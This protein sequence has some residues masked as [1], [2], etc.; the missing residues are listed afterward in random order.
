[1]F[2]G[3]GGVFAYRLR[4]SRV[5]LLLNRFGDVDRSVHELALV[6]PGSVISTVVPT[7]SW[8]WTVIW[9]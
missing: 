7:P 1:M 3:F 8:L 2:G 9:P 5:L 6:K 4:Y